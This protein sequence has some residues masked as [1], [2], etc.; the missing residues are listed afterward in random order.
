MKIQDMILDTYKFKNLQSYD[1][2]KYD[3]VQVKL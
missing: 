3:C 2:V 1:V